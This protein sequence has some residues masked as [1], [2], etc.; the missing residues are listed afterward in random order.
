ME[1]STVATT[2]DGDAGEPAG[3]TARKRRAILQAAEALFLDRG[4][5]GASVEEVA[6]RAAVSKQTVYKQFE[7][8]AA[9]FVA[10]VRAMTGEGSDRVQVEMRDPET[11]AEV[12]G[13][14]MGHG[15]RLLNVVLVPKLL[16]LRRLVISETDRFPELGRALYEG[17]PGRAI[18]GLAA[19]LRRWSDRGFLT[20]DDPM[21]A[22]TQFNW[23]V[24]GDP[25]NR[26][27]FFGSVHLSAAE[28][29]QHLAQSV[30][31]FLAAYGRRSAADG[32]RV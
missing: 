8:K 12:A 16:R 17:G 4:F 6:V 10:V 26:A 9:L 21:V 32:E 23:L 24:M 7:S 27:M 29:Q 20:L 31:V 2:H 19:A 13:A 5:V 3:R 28:Q 25:V 14:L 18:A 15:E 22:A 1:R 30:G 11:E